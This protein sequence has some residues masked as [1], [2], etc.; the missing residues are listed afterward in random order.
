MPEWLKGADCKSV[1][2]RLH[3]FESSLLHQQNNIVKNKERLESDERIWGVLAF[4]LYGPD[5]VPDSA[6]FY[7]G[8]VQW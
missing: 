6:A 7:A 2:L 4:G 5:V 1:G 3:W 8:V